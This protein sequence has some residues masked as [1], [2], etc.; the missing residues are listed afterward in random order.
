MWT[1]RVIEPAVSR[2]GTRDIYGVVGVQIDLLVSHRLPQTLDERLVPEQPSM[3]FW[4]TNASNTSGAEGAK[5]QTLDRLITQ[6]AGIPALD[7]FVLT[8]IRMAL[9]AS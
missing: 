6:D 1:A 8:K 9:Q 7:R 4:I 5:E 2:A 3:G